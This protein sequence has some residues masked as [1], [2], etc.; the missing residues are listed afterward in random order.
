MMTWKQYSA[1]DWKMQIQRNLDAAY[2]NIM[3]FSDMTVGSSRGWQLL[4]LIV[5]SQHGFKDA[6]TIVDFALDEAGGMDQLD[7]L[8]LKVV[9]QIASNNPKQAPTLPYA[10]STLPSAMFVPPSSVAFFLAATA[11]IFAS[12]ARRRPFNLCPS[13]HSTS[14]ACLKP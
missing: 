5:S 9:L 2:N 14:R 12:L 13:C 10:S 3:M 6:E 4:V 1:L 8:K 11:F 7:L